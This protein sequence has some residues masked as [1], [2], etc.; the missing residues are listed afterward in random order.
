MIPERNEHPLS[1]EKDQP[2]VFTIISK[3]TQI[4]SL[5][6]ET[7]AIHLSHQRVTNQHIFGLLLKSLP[8][9]KV[10]QAPPSIYDYKVPTLGPVCE[11]AGVEFRSGRIA[12]GGLYDSRNKIDFIYLKKALAFLE[13][14]KRK[15]GIF[16]RMLAVGIPEAE[17]AQ[18]Y[19]DLNKPKPTIRALADEVSLSPRNA[20]V[21]L[22]AF[23]HWLGIKSKS[24][25]VQA[26]ADHLET[27]L[28][29]L[30]K[31]KEEIQRITETLEKQRQPF[32]VGEHLPPLTLPPERWGTWQA[33]WE[34]QKK[35]PDL[36]LLLKDR[37]Y[38]LVALACYYQLFPGLERTASV[39]KIAK[40]YGRSRN[41]VYAWLHGALKKL[42]IPRDKWPSPQ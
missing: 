23:C 32:R 38:Y 7:Q 10:I 8:H 15:R 13:M 12:E 4:D 18:K 20:Q 2:L 41:A 16:K 9:L 28:K 36:F 24:A 3:P 22:E 1:P 17:M 5:P 30:E 6:P 39:T 33:I 19:F 11:Q 40:A 35:K 29:R 42:K 21:R 31:Q 34:K 27:R 37:P 26:R 14:S 25:T